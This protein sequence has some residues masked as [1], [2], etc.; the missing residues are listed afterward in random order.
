LTA[1][2]FLGFAVG[3]SCFC[4]PVYGRLVPVVGLGAGAVVAAGAAG[5]VVAVVELPVAV[6][7][8]PDLEL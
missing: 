5:A 3:I 8:V 7:A 4:Y 1:G 6:A 2:L